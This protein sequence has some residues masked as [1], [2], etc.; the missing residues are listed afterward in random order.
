MFYYLPA[1]P[2]TS[3]HIP[4]TARASNQMKDQS[5]NRVEEINIWIRIWGESIGIPKSA[6]DNER[7]QHEIIDMNDGVGLLRALQSMMY[8]DSFPSEAIKNLNDSKYQLE[9]IEVVERFAKDCR[10]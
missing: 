9:C 8:T 5:T 1:I 7:I 4:D 10:Q 3:N 6:W 2:W